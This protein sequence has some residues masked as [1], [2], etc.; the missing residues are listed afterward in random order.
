MTVAERIK[1]LQSEHLNNEWTSGDSTT[2]LPIWKVKF[3]LNQWNIGKNENEEK[4][5]SFTLVT[6]EIV[7]DIDRVKR[8][9]E[10][11]YK[12]NEMIWE[13]EVK[14]MITADEIDSTPVDH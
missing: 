5:E 1:P 12:N 14:K 9:D 8:V 3:S 10:W 6:R 7:S 2:I 4:N 11:S 13:D